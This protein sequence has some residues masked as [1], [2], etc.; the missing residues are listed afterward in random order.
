M[1]NRQLPTTLIVKGIA[2]AGKRAAELAPFELGLIDRDTNLTVDTAT[3]HR[4]KTYQIVLGSPST[5]A[6]NPH[7][8][9]QRGAQMPIR[10]LPIQ[11]IDKA[12]LFDGATSEAK[13]FIA[14]L[15]YDGI[16]E[17]KNLQ[18]E[19]GRT[20][21]LMIQVR[22]KNV[23]DVFGRNLMEIISFHTDCCDGC[24]L[25]EISSKT[26]D[27]LME[28]ITKESFY[29]NHYFKHELVKVCCPVEAPFVKTDF[30]KYNLTVCDNGDVNALANVQ[31]QYP[32]IKIDRVSRVDSYSTY[33]FCQPSADAAPAD[34]SQVN[35]VLV[36]CGVCPQG[37]TINEGQTW[38]V[39]MDYDGTTD[40]LTAVQVVLATATSATLMNVDGSQGTFQVVLPLAYAHT[41]IAD[42]EMTYLGDIAP[43]CTQDAAT[44]TA[45]V[46]A[47]GYYKVARTV[48]MTAK[49]V[50]C[51]GSDRLTEIAAIYD[52]NYDV[53]AGSV[54]IK[55]TTD[56]LTVYTMDQ[57]NTDCLEDGCDV[58]GKDGAVWGN[59]PA[60]EGMFW[61]T[62][63]CE[64]WTVDG[65]TGCP[66][67]PVEVD[68]NCNV[69]IK[70]TG[71]FLDRNT[72]RCSFAIDDQVFVDP[73]EI[74]VT[75]ID[76][77]TETCA[78]LQV[79]WTVVQY[80]EIAQGLGALLAR[81]EVTSRN[82]D[83]YIYSNPKSE[84]GVVWKDALG[85][86]YGF[87]P[88]KYYNHINIY[89]NSDAQRY[90]YKSD[91]QNRELIQMYVE[92]T[93]GVLLDQLKT[94]LNSTLLS[95][96]VAGLLV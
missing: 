4:D 96:S 10:S 62:D 89:H 86:E 74:E 8:G 12:H 20:Y 21:G 45:W 22:G 83:A 52:G 85:Y 2:A 61:T 69:G 56:C 95:H 43:F 6:D 28:A 44:T 1:L 79:D 42:V 33:Q 16:N 58:Y 82:Y 64:G 73:I 5:G 67:P 77:E 92:H 40:P 35:N 71:A 14:Y 48:T 94:F 41:P 88:E 81:R 37:Y 11:K 13:P 38:L 80:P 90:A 36:D 87:E 15:G 51:D 70:F 78:P 23:R 76:Q 30:S 27:K 63:P 57:L 26:A 46:E 34:F 32:G 47:T 91:S 60:F 19:C 29:V 31:I 24:S 53:V 25:D 66:V 65:E 39:K 68:D 49:N 50:E 75:L 18:F 3:Y 72:Q 54:A 7:F 17:C 59:I 93:N 84:M 55:E 9:D